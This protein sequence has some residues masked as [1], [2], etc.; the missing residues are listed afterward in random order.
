LQLA[1]VSFFRSR[2]GVEPLLLADDVLGELDPQRRR[3]FWATL[4]EARQVIATGTSLPDAELGA[5]EV[6]R[7]A[8]GTFAK[9]NA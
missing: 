7:V 8:A 3:R 4:G 1:Q 9:E 2:S 6:F 5:W